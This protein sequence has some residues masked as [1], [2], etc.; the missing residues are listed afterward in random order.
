MQDW[1][2]R[3]DKLEPVAEKSLDDRHRG[4]L[5][6]KI[7]IPRIGPWMKLRVDGRRDWH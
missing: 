1:G 2:H 3:M 7:A 6:K 5:R 4:Q